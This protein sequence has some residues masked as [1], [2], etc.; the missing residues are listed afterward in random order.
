MRDNHMEG[1]GA[2]HGLAK[3]GQKKK[4]HSEEEK[5]YDQNIWIN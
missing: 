3:I 4:K 1:D 5:D 2:Q